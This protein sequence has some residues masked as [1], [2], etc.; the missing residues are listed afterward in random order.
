MGLFS[1][2]KRM[3]TLTTEQKDVNR[4]YAKLLSAKFETPGGLRATQWDQSKWGPMV[5]PLDQ[6]FGSV[7]SMIN[8]FDPTYKQGL[9]NTLIRQLTTARMGTYGPTA[10]NL[11]DPAQTAKYLQKTVVNPMLNQFDTQLEP[12]IREA[13]AGVGAFSSQQG[14]VTGDVLRDLGISMSQQIGAAQLQNQQLNAQMNFQGNE[15]AAARQLQADLA[16]FE[17]RFRGN[18]MAIDA[19]NNQRT[20]PLQ[21][22]GMMSQALGPFQ[23][24]ADVMSDVNRQE[25]ARTSI[26]NSPWIP[27]ALGYLGTPMSQLYNQ[28]GLLGQVAPVLG[29]LAGGLGGA[30]MMPAIGSRLA[31]SAAAGSW[32]QRLGGALSGPWGSVVGGLGGFFGGLGG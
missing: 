32:G 14:R 7:R 2:T 3:N 27:Q 23:Q 19:L 12:R 29:G 26:E 31:S 1:E 28:Q 25:F 16:E 4:L 5:A 8:S 13:F 22:A 15:S 6:G 30:M 21:Y 9:E 24:R 20:Q 11:L 17:G 10:Q 18:A